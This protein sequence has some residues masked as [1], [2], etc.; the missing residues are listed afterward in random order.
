[1]RTKSK[2]GYE[3]SLQMKSASVQNVLYLSLIWKTNTW[4]HC[5][6]R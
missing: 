3:Q 5:T 6:I 4:N 1:M 2:E